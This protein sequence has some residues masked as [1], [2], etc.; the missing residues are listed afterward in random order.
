ML[1]TAGSRTFI[2]RDS[3]APGG[4]WDNLDSETQPSGSHL[5]K[6]PG[7]HGATGPPGS[8]LGRGCRHHHVGK[9]PAAST[10][11]HTVRS[12]TSSRTPQ[13]LPKV[14]GCRGPS[15]C[16]SSP[17]GP[18][19]ARALNHLTPHRV[20]A[21]SCWLQGSLA[22]VEKQQEGERGRWGGGVVGRGAAGEKAPLSGSGNT[23]RIQKP[24]A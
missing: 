15:T 19:P 12:V 21:T 13:Q 1:I 14:T 16:I 4:G 11:P 22:G 10:K 3:S 20:P 17:P 2:W 5:S 18:P 7:G 6:A 9:P 8:V 23:T 24:R